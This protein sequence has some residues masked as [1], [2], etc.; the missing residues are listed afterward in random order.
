M[1]GAGAC[2]KE[3]QDEEARKEQERLKKIALEQEAHEMQIQEVAPKI[4]AMEASWNRLR[5]ITGADEPEE[6][7]AYWEGLQSKEE[8]MRQLVAASEASEAAVKVPP[9]A[10]LPRRLRASRGDTRCS[11]RAVWCAEARRGA[12][13]AAERHAG[14]GPWRGRRRRQRRRLRGRHRGGAP[15]HVRDAQEVPAAA[16]GVHQRGARAEKHARAL[17]GRAAGDHRR[18]AHAHEQHPAGHAAAAG[19]EAR[20]PREVRAATLPPPLALPSGRP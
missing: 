10:L 15:R 20:A 12:A 14:T 8:N 11:R 1:W 9:R 19:Q 7:I 18:G 2:S 3:R 17:A 6:V 13:A 16:D 4:E 5:T